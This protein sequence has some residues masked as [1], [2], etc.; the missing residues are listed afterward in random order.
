MLVV[1]A[2]EII[3]AIAEHVPI[4]ALAWFLIK[5]NDR[6]VSVNR[7]RLHLGTLSIFRSVPC[8]Q[9]QANKMQ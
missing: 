1:M 6:P 5:K 2:A 9:H 3:A 4:I 8:N 7:F